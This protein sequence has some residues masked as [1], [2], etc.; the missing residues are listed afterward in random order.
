MSIIKW[1]KAVGSGKAKGHF[2]QYAEDVIVRKQFP[3]RKR[4]GR[5]L[6][7]GAYHPFRFSNTAYLWMKGWSGV[8]VDANPKSIE[9]FRKVR[10][11]DVNLCAAI[12][13]QSAIEQGLTEIELRLPAKRDDKSGISATGTLNERIAEAG[14]MTD[15]VTVPA[16]AIQQILQAHD[17]RGLDYLNVDVEGHDEQII[18]DFDFSCCKPKVITIEDYAPNLVAA[19]VTPTARILTGQGYELFARMG[20]TSVFRLTS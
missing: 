17:L 3:K 5:Y 1:I 19:V 18:A 15:T 7:I 11:G 14:E 20:P 8:N 2:G 9:L 12:V 4:D 6:D 16:Q 10:K 13:P